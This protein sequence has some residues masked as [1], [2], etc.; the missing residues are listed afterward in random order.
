MR[1]PCKYILLFFV[2]IAILGCDDKTTTAKIL[3]QAEKLMDAQPD[4]SY[5]LLN[6]LVFPGNM[7][8]KEM[9]AYALLMEQ[10]IYKKRWFIR[11]FV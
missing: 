3:L 9:A 5:I 7:S 10:A 1:E 8:E 11:D 6:Q 2:V 4:S